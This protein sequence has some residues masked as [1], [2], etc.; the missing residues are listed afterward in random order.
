MELTIEKRI[1]LLDLL[2]SEYTIPEEMVDCVAEAIKL[3]KTQ[4]YS[5]EAI[6]NMV[7]NP[8]SLSKGV[9]FTTR[10]KW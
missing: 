8:Q 9:I 10:K 6:N 4:D 2:L 1:A 5:N 7:K 3:Y